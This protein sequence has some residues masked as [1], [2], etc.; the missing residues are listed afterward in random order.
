MVTRLEF[1]VPDALFDVSSNAS[2]IAALGIAGNINSAARVFMLNNVWRRGD[3]KICDIGQRHLA[4][5]WCIDEDRAE[6]P[7]IRAPLFIAPD[8]YVEDFLVFVKLPDFGSANESH[9]R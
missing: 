1:D 9:C 4:A 8:G 6:A 3:S 5:K 2:Q 7:Q